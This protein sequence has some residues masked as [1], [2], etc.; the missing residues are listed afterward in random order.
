MDCEVVVLAPLC[1]CWQEL[2]KE[3]VSVMDLDLAQG[4]P[5]LSRQEVACQLHLPS[6]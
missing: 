3:L 4:S 2:L 5:A 6:L 1:R